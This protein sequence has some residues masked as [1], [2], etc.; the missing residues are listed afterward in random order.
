[1]VS[2]VIQGSLTPAQI[3]GELSLVRGLQYQQLWYLLYIP[4][5]GANFGGIEPRLKINKPASREF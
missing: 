4:R 1:M 5:H 2:A 3:L